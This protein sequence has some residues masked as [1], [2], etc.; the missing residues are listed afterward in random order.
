M[1]PHDPSH[2]HDAGVELIGRVRDLGLGHIHARLGIIVEPSVADVANDADDLA[3]RLVV[4]FAHHA[5]PDDDPLAQRIAIGPE[6]TSHRLVDHGYGLPNRVVPLVERAA[7]HRRD[8]ENLEVPGGHGC[9]TAAA[10][11][12]R[13]FEGASR[14]DE[15]KPVAALQ[16]NAAGGAGNLYARD[17]LDALHAPADNVLHCLRRLKALLGKRHS[18]RDDVVDVVARVDIG[19]RDRGPDQKA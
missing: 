18:H 11:R 2:R 4:E 19:E 6:L 3:L 17:R 8:S 9:P 13:T 10:V 5:A 7:A 16:R 12:S 1:C 15:R 14:D